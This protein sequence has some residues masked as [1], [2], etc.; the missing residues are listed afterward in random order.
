M[1]FDKQGLR[2][3]YVKRIE[4]KSQKMNKNWENALTKLHKL[5]MNKN[6]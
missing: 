1:K 4:L 3:E 5:E 6:W 2:E